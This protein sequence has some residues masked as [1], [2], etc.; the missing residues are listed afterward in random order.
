VS[1]RV[2][3]PPVH[4][5]YRCRRRPCLATCGAPN[6]CR[7]REFSIESVVRAKPQSLSSGG[8][9]R[10]WWREL[11]RPSSLPYLSGRCPPQSCAGALPFD[12]PLLHRKSGSDIG[13]SFENAKISSFE[14][15]V[16]WT[17]TS[18]EQYRNRS[19]RNQ[20]A[21]CWCGRS[22]SNRHSFWE[23]HFE[24]RASTSS[25]T[26]AIP[27]AA[28]ENHRGRE[29]IASRTRNW[30]TKTGSPG[31]PSNLPIGLGPADRGAR[32]ASLST[33]GP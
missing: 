18:K 14:K 6:P 22:E 11:S 21:Y 8:C 27:K 24:C 7:G 16:P 12:G 9:F 23:R 26:P 28:P 10:W 31:R 30:Q 1:R 25:A 29:P 19:L 17:F 13:Q 32:R 20:R 5:A 33:G 3:H 4:A 2:L 15:K